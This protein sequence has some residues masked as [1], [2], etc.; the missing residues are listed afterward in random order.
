[1]NTFWETEAGGS[2][3]WGQSGLYSEILYQKRKKNCVV[4]FS[5]FIVALFFMLMYGLQRVDGNFSFPHPDN[6]NVEWVTQS[7]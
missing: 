7:L 3:V 6:L 4:C 5:V 1:M 2:Q